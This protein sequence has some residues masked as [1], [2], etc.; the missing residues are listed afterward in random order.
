MCDS[1]WVS[2]EDEKPELNQLCLVFTTWEGRPHS[3]DIS[4]YYKMSNCG[5]DVFTKDLNTQNIR[6]THWQP[7]PSPPNSI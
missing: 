5:K 2:V 4:R 1:E 6:V 7:L 3:Y